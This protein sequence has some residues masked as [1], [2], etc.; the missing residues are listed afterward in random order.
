MREANKMTKTVERVRRTSINGTRNKLTVRGKDPDYEYRHV[1][2]IDGR[3]EDL[4]ERGYEIVE[5]KGIEVGDKRVASASPTGSV[6]ATNSGD[7][8]KLILMRIKKE[9]Y[10]E[11]KKTKEAV[12]NATEEQLRGQASNNGLTGNIKL[13]RG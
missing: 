1:L 5:N 8:R 9:F 11:D 12:V 2:D 10:E 6:V 7:G 4:S 13:T 3:V